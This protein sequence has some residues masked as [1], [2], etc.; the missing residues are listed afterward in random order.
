MVMV[1]LS[2]LLVNPVSATTA[3]EVVGTGQNYAVVAYVTTT[4]NTYKL[5][6]Q[7]FGSYHEKGDPDEPMVVTV[8]ATVGSG[9]TETFGGSFGKT[10]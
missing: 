7:S 3:K 8:N 6:S 2:V 5:Y 9:T 1:L 4:Y 10:L